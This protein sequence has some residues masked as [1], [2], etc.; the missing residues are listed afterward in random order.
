MAKHVLVRFGMNSWPVSGSS[1][2]KGIQNLKESI[3]KSFKVIIA[4]ADSDSLLIQ[5]KEEEFDDFVDS[6]PQVYPVKEEF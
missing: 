4:E 6:V 1:F 2:Y 5:V 3:L